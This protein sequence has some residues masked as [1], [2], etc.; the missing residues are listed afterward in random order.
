MVRN[1]AFLSLGMLFAATSCFAE[2]GNIYKNELIAFKENPEYIG[3]FDKDISSSL[4]SIQRDIQT[5]AHTSFS[6]R[7]LLMVFFLLDPVVVTPNTMPQLYSYI[8][9]V[10]KSQN[11]KTPVVFISRKERFFNAAASKLFMSCGGIMIGQRIV[12]ETSDA[13]LEGIIA[14]E[15]GHIKYN[16]INKSLLIAALVYALFPTHICDNLFDDYTYTIPIATL[17]YNIR[18]GLA[19][20]L[21]HELRSL[22]INAIINKRFEREADEFAYKIMDKG[23][24]LIEFF[25]LLEEKEDHYEQGFLDTYAKIQENKDNVGLINYL[26]LA[27]RYYTNRALNYIDK[28]Y[29]WL[30]HNTFLGAHPSHEARIKAVRE[31]Q[32]TVAKQADGGLQAA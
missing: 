22:I 14:H 3:I 23:D 1:V 32:E 27:Q 8:D 2:S 25:E 31:Y 13:A 6:Q 9:S 29:K 20:Y 28:A 21:N 5:Y 16:H 18:I 12:V 17:G 7:F 30:Y 26:S 11:M 24:G 15:L 4:N 10:C 19:S